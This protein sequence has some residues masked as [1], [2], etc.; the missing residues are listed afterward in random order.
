MGEAGFAALGA[1]VSA[2]AL[3]SIQVSGARGPKSRRNT[4]R[5]G[6]NSAPAPESSFG[7]PT[8]S[9]QIYAHG[10]SIGFA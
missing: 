5:P 2:V 3:Q 6:S 9:T 8:D 1:G 10:G 4:S 7:K